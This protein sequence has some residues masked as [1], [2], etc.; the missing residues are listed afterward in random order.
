[1][2]FFF[3]A[4]LVLGVLKQQCL[5]VQSSLYWGYFFLLGGPIH[6][7]ILSKCDESLFVTVN[8]FLDVLWLLGWCIRISSLLSWLHLYRHSPIQKF[9]DLTLSL[10]SFS[11]QRCI[12]FFPCPHLIWMI[13][14][15]Y[16]FCRPDYI[17][18]DSIVII[19]TFNVL[20]YQ[21]VLF[22]PFDKQERQVN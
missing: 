22:L 20:G 9:C 5:L 10:F 21:L 8:N 4:Q 15:L 11:R 7:I 12:L 13:L 16:Y 2:M 19:N 14:M 17:F 3:H 1:M 18:D 6:G